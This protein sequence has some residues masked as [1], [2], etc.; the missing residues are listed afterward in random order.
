MILS[1]LHNVAI[2]SQNPLT[3]K[4]AKILRKERRE[5]IKQNFNFVCFAQTFANFAVKK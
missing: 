1:A 5:L 4:D 2:E 3:A